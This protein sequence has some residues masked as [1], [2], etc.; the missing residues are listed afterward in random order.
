MIKKFMGE[1]RWLSNFHLIDIEYQGLVFP[2]TENAYQAAK[3]PQ[4]SRKTF[5]DISPSQARK[6]GQ[7]VNMRKDWDE[8]KLSVMHEL[9]IIKFK[10]LDLRQKLLDTRP[11]ILIEGNRW[12]DKFWGVDLKTGIGANHLGRILMEVRNA[13]L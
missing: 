9:Q 13:L 2:S 4:D 8:V 12:G 11:K 3:V 7:I 10:D 6:L 1:Y 5:L